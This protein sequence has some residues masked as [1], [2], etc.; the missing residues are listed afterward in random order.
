MNND[1]RY[2]AVQL[3]LAWEKSRHTLDRCIDHLEKKLAGLS[4]KDRNLFNALVF[5]VFRHRN[6]LDHIIGKYA[7]RPLR[8]ID[9]AALYI[10]RTG[11]YQLH[12]MDK[13][14]DF[15][16]IDTCVTL[17][18][19]FGGQKQAGFVNAVLRSSTRKRP[20]LTMPEP[21]C[22]TPADIQ[23]CYSLPA[24]LTERWVAQYGLQPAGMLA[25]ENCRTP[26]ITLRTNTLK[27]SRQRLVETLEPLCAQTTPTD[28]SPDGIHIHH[29]SVPLH[30]MDAFKKGWF[31]AQDEAA[32]IVTQV[33]TPKPQ[34]RILDACAGLG[35]KTHHIA[36]AMEDEG[37]VTAV[38]IDAAKLDS[39]GL[40][41]ARLGITAIN[42]RAVDIR[43]TTIKDF[44]GYFDRVL[45]DAPCTGLGVLTRNPDT[46]W[47][48]SKADIPRMAARQKKILNAAA[49]LVKPSGIL[50][51]AVCSCENE[52]NEEV[53]AAFLSKRKDFLIDNEF[54]S[55]TLTPLMNSDG[56]FKTYPKHI[57]MDGFFVARLKRR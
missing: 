35:G 21:D 45:V 7:T 19:K 57:H 1:P 10:L 4:R 33:L 53:L 3:F 39:L 41:S 5:G 36:Q 34:E 51:Y 8:R 42:H 9:P 46:K 15:A 2:R 14:P 49:N 50:V 44:D 26:G 27:T 56:F 38:D 32:Q 20:D 23:T 48:R 22:I 17:A 47:R 12:L 28:I 43:K 24:W 55:D 6:L 31:Q 13:V 25:R 30:E 37:S 11:M 54:K 52:E 29:P 16:A 18:K 40:E